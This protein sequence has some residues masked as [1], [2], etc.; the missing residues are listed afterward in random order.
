MTPAKI[1]IMGLPGAGKTA[2]AEVL[3]PRIGAVWFNNDAVRATISAHLGFSMEDRITQAR[4]MG[5]LCDQVVKA[6]HHAI[7]D[8]VCPTDLTRQAFQ[9]GGPAFIV[10]VDRIKHSRFEDTNRLFEPPKLFDVRVTLEGRPQEWAD[11]IAAA[12]G[13]PSVPLNF[14]GVNGAAATAIGPAA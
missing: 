2:L 10:W 4:H 5:W 6:G 12:L 3:A 9:T 13:R 14:A 7:A 11:R 8:F 1:L